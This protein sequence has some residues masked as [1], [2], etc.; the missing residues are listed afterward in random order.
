MPAVTR[1]SEAARNAPHVLVIGA[2]VVGCACAY[3]LQ[4]AG[5][6]V[7]VVDA[8]GGP[9]TGASFANGGQLSYSYVEPLAT[10]TALRNAPR[11]LLDAN[12]PLRLK[13][14]AEPAQ[15]RWLAAFAAACTTARAQRTT[16]A[17]LELAAASRA[18]LHAWQHEEAQR[19][20][21]LEFAHARNGKLVLQATAAAFDAAAR[22]CRLQQ[23]LG[24][25]QT[26]LDRDGCVAREPALA[27]CAQRY[28]GGVWT[29]SEEVGDA[30]ALTLALAQR[31][32]AR[33]ARLL[34]KTPV[35]DLPRDGARGRLRGALTSQ[36]LIE[37]EHVVLCAGHASAALVRR[38]GIALPIEP[39]KGY[40]I[41][42]AVTDP[43]RA[44]RAS[45]T[46]AGRKIVYAPLGG[47]LRVAG[48][49]ELVGDD[50]APDPRRIEAMVRAVDDTFPG[51]CDL[52][53]VWPWAGLRP[54][55]PDGRPRIGPTAV[56]G[57]WLNTGHGPLGLT[58]ACGSAQ[59][60]AG[61]ILGQAPQARDPG[62][63]A[64][65]A[66]GAALERAPR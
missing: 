47:Q 37:A 23:A 48:M 8:A 35:L 31:L 14:R 32:A 43:S 24:C 4:R 22:Q 9:G 16:R 36:G 38:L 27:A 55:T 25:E 64:P 39:I 19:G 62:Q 34:F 44:P 59:R 11:W 40:S 13:L 6:Q 61:A 45:I 33:G 20:T 28:V 29:P 54:A 58:L 63:D 60:L 30:H 2:G 15:W 42:V 7:T 50:T 56:P 57:L 51:A 52:N 26:L 10:P 12:S 66:C 41:T 17:L 3:A 1:A 65:P 5:A 18:A 53:D 49:A 21:P 46:D